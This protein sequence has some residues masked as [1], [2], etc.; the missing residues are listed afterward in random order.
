MEIVEINSK[1]EIHGW[2]KGKRECTSE[3]LLINPYNGCEHRC[4][5]CYAQKLWGYFALSTK[6]NKIFVCSDFDKV[7]AQQLSSLQVASC[8]YL[9]PVTDPFQPVNRR[10]KLS[11]KIIKVFVEQN[12][13]IEFITKGVIPE[14]ALNLISRQKDSFGQVSILTLDERLRKYLCPGGATTEELF[15]N[16]ER[17]AKR[18][19]FAVVRI[20]PIFPYL[21]D[22]EEDLERLVKQSASAGAK[23]IIASIV[24]IP[25]KIKDKFYKNLGKIDRK[26]PAKYV[27]LYNEKIDG[28]Y[29]AQIPY[30]KKVFATLGD[31]CKENNLTLGLCMEYELIDGIPTGLNRRFM[32]S[33]NCEGMNIPIYIRKK[34]YFEPAAKCNGACLTCKEAKCGIQ[35]LAMLKKRDD[36]KAKKSFKLSDYRRWSKLI[37]QSQR[38]TLWK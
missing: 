2:W 7:I 11:E 13:P 32:T 9:S 24:D 3:R 26:L 29:N 38:T 10:Y 35:E 28:D 33:E 25:W 18:K 12:L 8:G 19:I 6:E 14:E 22:G 15:E 34:D 4:F 5:F 27:N 21:T 30:R 36:P 20:D 37:S 23:H 16:I 1:K 17:L 31:I